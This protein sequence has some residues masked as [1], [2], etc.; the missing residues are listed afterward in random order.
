MTTVLI[1]DDALIM[2]MMLKDLLTKNEFEVIG[3]AENGEEAVEAFKEL[4]PDLA[5]IDILMP[6]KDGLNAAQEILNFNPDAKIIMI[7]AM[8]EREYIAQAQEMGVKSFILK[9]F[10][11]P[12]VIE[13]LKKVAQN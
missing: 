11:P 7:S 12:K 9:P 4:N 13:T 5:L 10:S 6:V 3:E 2:R 8:G 1:A